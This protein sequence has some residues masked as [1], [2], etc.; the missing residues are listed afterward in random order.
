MLDIPEKISLDL[1]KYTVSV[2]SGSHSD[3]EQN[4]IPVLSNK[5][6]VLETRTVYVNG[7]QKKVIPLDLLNGA[8]NTSRINKNFVIEYTSNPIW[9]AIQALP[10]MANHEQTSTVAMTNAFFA[11]KLGLDIINKNPSIESVFRLWQ[12]EGANA[13]KSNLQKNQELKDIV[14]SESPWVLD[15]LKEE[16]QRSNL[17]QF[18]D[19]VQMTNNLSNLSRLIEKR[20][21]SNGGFSWIP[22]GRD[23][24]LV[25]LYFLEYVGKLNHLGIRTEFESNTIKRALVYIDQRL[26]ELY[27]K[28]KKTNSKIESYTPNYNEVFHL[29][30]RSHFSDMDYN[31]K[32]NN[33]YNFYQKQAEKYWN[34]LDLFSQA[35]LGTVL[36]RNANDLH[37]EISNSMIERSFTSDELGRYWNVGNGFKWSQLPV[38]RHT[39]ILDFFVESNVNLDIVDQLKIWLLKHKQVNN[40][41]TGKSTAAAVY[42]L[43]E[44]GSKKQTSIV[45]DKDVT[46]SFSGDPV[47]ENNSNEP[48]T[49]YRKRSF[50]N[51]EINSSMGSL[52][53]E[54]NSDNISWGGIY[55]QYLEEV[56]K[57]EEDNQGPLSISKEIYKIK[58]DTKKG[59]QLIRINASNK[60]DPG[61]VI[62]SRMILK[63]DRDMEY[64]NIKD[65]RGSGV[66][67][68]KSL[69]RYYWRNGLSY[70]HSIKDVSDNYFIEYLPKGT[71][72]FEQR[73]V[74]VH[75]G[76]YGGGIS[77]AQCAYAPEFSSHSKGFMIQVK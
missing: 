32:S 50:Q 14:L 44:K 13:L 18:F 19:P 62:V 74:V 43:L 5:L 53:I 9:Y 16:E 2:S 69:S 72:V 51:N 6:P 68:S 27:Q 60:L 7:N 42:A 26:E 3:A 61:D 57:I 47:F 31:G 49:G 35:L 1:L 67:P 46:I 75:K 73:Q 21:T 11:N 66:E 38:E 39:A 20:Q 28:L 56:D 71:H 17:S 36:H 22:G 77:T 34:N 45:T 8:D 55:Y 41:K 23:N 15:A 12:K 24:L 65:M 40:W 25:T 76:T 30:V 29:F 48:G 33:A 59:E 58:V 63:S 52:I 64:I 37:Q 10:F 54:N 70:Y 4:I